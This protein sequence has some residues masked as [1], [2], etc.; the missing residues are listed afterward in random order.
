MGGGLGSIEAEIEISLRNNP[1]MQQRLKP[2]LA[3]QGSHYG[4]ALTV[5]ALTSLT[6]LVRS[7]LLQLPS[8]GAAP[9]CTPLT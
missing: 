9:F 5:P 8:G 1:V 7:I 2:G 3:G 6:A 4:P